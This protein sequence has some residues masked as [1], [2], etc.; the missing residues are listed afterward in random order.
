MKKILLLIVFG[1]VHFTVNAQCESNCLDVFLNHVGNNPS[2]EFC[3]EVTLT[4]NND[5]ALYNA[6]NCLFEISAEELVTGNNNLLAS[7]DEGAS[8]SVS[9]I[10]IVYLIRALSFEGFVSPFEAISAD[11]DGDEVVSTD[12]I[13]ALRNFILGIDLSLPHHARIA[14]VDHPFV[15]LNQLDLGSNFTFVELSD[16]EASDLLE[17]TLINSGDLSAF[18]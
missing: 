4:L 10:D 18:H 14:R 9:T 2:S 6:G 5:E 3:D 8:G 7:S 15:D 13:I 12:D 11:V 16:D 1:A 17:L